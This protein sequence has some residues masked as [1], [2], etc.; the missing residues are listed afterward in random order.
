MSIL[1][2]C[3]FTFWGGSI[4]F[5]AC[6]NY[7]PIGFG[8]QIDLNTTILLEWQMC[9]SVKCDSAVV[10]AVAV[11]VQLCVHVDQPAGGRGGAGWQ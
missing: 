9:V 4:Q 2:V 6:R 5:V 7:E 11:R 1:F 3:K 10:R 8:F